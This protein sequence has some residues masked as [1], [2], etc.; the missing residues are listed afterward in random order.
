MRKRMAKFLCFILAVTMLPGLISCSDP[1]GVT[2]EEK[3]PASSATATQTSPAIR[4][5]EPKTETP[6]VVPA[7]RNSLTGLECDPSL[8]GKRPVAI[9]FNNLKE[10]IPQSGISKCDIVYEVLAEG[11]ILRLMGLSVDYENLGD[12]GSIR[13]ARPYMVEISLSH[14]AVF[15]HAGASARAD[16]TVIRLGA[17]E[18]D[19]VKRGPFSANGKAVFWRNQDRLNAGVPLEHTLFTSGS[20]IAAAIAVKKFR[21][22]RLDASATAF[23]FDYTNSPLGTGKSA[24]YVKVPHSNYSV[25]EFKYNA[26]DGLYYHHQ[27]G[28][29]HMDGQTNKQIAVNNV[30]VLF[31]HQERY[32]DD[33]A[34]T[35]KIDLVGEGKGYYMNGGEYTPITW[36]RSSETGAFTYYNENGTELPVKCGKSYVSIANNEIASKITIS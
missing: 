15:V 13:S 2:T 20:S 32:A 19:G 6:P 21:T 24:T 31:T 14:D 9:V 10:A 11:G 22:T 1:E 29:P 16:A 33:T 23:K 3:I 7:N 4:T 25:S 34:G 26:N 8:V 36:K 12:L 30:F 27:Y 18:I 17:D 35:L 28:A 5:D